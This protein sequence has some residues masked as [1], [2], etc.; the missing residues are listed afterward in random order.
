MGPLSF[1]NDTGQHAWE[2]EVSD[3]KNYDGTITSALNYASQIHYYL[4]NAQANYWGYWLLDANSGFTDNSALTDKNSNIAKRA[5]AIGNWSRFVLPGWHMVPVSNSTSLLVTAFI[6]PAGNA[7][8]VVA[9]NNGS[10][11]VS[12]TFSVGDNYGFKRD[13]LSHV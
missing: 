6:N 10:S 7:G 4:A 9:V 2:T 5:Y 12:V 11:P 13:S 8:T 3:S 1:G